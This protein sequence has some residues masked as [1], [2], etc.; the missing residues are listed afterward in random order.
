MTIRQQGALDRFVKKSYQLPAAIA[1]EEEHWYTN[2]MINEAINLTRLPRKGPVHINIP[3]RE[4]LYS[5]TKKHFRRNV[6]LKRLLQ[7]MFSRTKL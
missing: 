7:G 1:S 3:L 4:P 2:R 6:S 5:F